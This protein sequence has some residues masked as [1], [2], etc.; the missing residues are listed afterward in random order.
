MHCTGVTDRGAEQAEPSGGVEPHSMPSKAALP[1]TASFKSDEEAV[2]R[3]LQ[4]PL[5]KVSTAIHIVCSDGT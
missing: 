2:E 5:T 4:C 1:Q 3:L